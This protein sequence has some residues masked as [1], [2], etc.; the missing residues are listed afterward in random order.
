MSPRPRSIVPA[1]GIVVVLSLLSW[2]GGPGI[3]RASAPLPVLQQTPQ[4]QPPAPQEQ[5]PAAQEPQQASQEPQT[6]AGEDPTSGEADSA[7]GAR[8]ATVTLEEVEA[9]RARVEGSTELD[10]ETKKT[11]LERYGRA[12]ASLEKRAEHVA[13]AERFRKQLENAPARLTEI[14]TPLAQVPETPAFTVPAFAPL[15][16]L[17]SSLREAEAA[18]AEQAKRLAQAEQA[19]RN[20]TDRPI[21]IPQELAAAREQLAATTKALDGLEQEGGT[22]QV[23]EARR[24]RLLAEKMEFEARIDALQAELEFFQGAKYFDKQV[25]LARARQKMADDK[26][27]KLRTVVEEKRAAEAK[28][29]TRRAERLVEGLD[30]SIPLVDELAQRTVEYA[31]SAEEIN[32]NLSEAE[33]RTR[34]AEERREALQQELQ[35]IEDRLD[36]IGLVDEMGR[37]LRRKKRELRSPMEYRARLADLKKEIARLEAERI[38]LGEVR[39]ALTD[40]DAF[41]QSRMDAAGAPPEA[42][43]PVR[44]IVE[45]WRGENG[46]VT[47]LVERY[48]RYLTALYQRM[49]AE[50][51]LLEQT[52]S[53][54]SFIDERVLW[55]RSTDPGSTF[56]P[57][58]I[59]SE[60]RWLGSPT[61]WQEAVQA[62]LADLREH[63]LVNGSAVL[64]LGLLFFLQHRFRRKLLEIG[65]TADRKTSFLP[66]A[67]VF[68]LTLLLS[69]V[70]PA[71]IWVVAWRLGSSADGS[72]FTLALAD[73]LRAVAVVY[74]TFDFFGRVLRPNGLADSHFKW[75]K[76]SLVTTR[77]HLRW[78][79]AVLI[80]VV[81]V[82]ATTDGASG[83]ADWS[84]SLG[85]IACIVGF[86]ALALFCRVVLRPSGEAIGEALKRRSDGWAYRLRHL[87]YPATVLI[88]LGFVALI[89]LGYY[90]TVHELSFRLALTA[91]LLIAVI[92]VEAMIH[93]W[94]LL[95]RRRLALER[96]RKL[97]EESRSESP[98]PEAGEVIE[99]PEAEQAGIDFST[100]SEQNKKLTRLVGLTT[101]VLGLWF[102]WADVLPAF[103]ILQHV[104]V[105][106][107]GTE[108]PVTL[109]ALLFSALY[110]FATYV[111]TKNLPGLLE[112]SVLQRT[113]LGAG[114]RYAIT[115][116]SRY[117]IVIVGLILAF[118]G[119]GI[120]WSKLQWLVAA[121]SVGLGFGLQEIVANFVSGI[122]LLV[123][124]PI[125]VGDIVTV[126]T[127]SG[128]VTRIRIRATTITDW[129]RR[130]LVVPNKSFI[131][132]D[133]V[134]WTLSDT[135][136]RATYTVG[137]AYGSDVRKVMEVLI[138]SA[139]KS[140]Y[141]LEDP[142]PFAL[143]N[144]FGDSSLN[145]TLY[146]YLP[147]RDNYIAVVNDIN[148]RIN[149]A[150]AEAGIEIPFPQ[151]DIHVRDIPRRLAERIDGD[152]REPAGD[153]TPPA[154]AAASGKGAGKKKG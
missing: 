3:A 66:T 34:R 19:Q 72:P 14:E 141:V 13:T 43:E 15:E 31:R 85:S 2:L 111:A 11:L 112:I 93:R 125:R 142:A 102:V 131:T 65:K 105:W 73:G 91:W 33:E 62:F 64:I 55:I 148:T 152:G 130:E 121:L 30:R 53:F 68:V 74:L 140:E 150:L 32:R 51:Q 145:F 115:T 63:P 1:S 35:S 149:D 22:R 109:A 119:I 116:I 144:G 17:E 132:G 89:A 106:G 26:V 60:L 16:E 122:I 39:R 28:R 42:Q 6:P 48:D 126:G 138:D 82:V 100:I 107:I 44:K 81:F 147:N 75:S 61:K 67:Y 29:A 87:W 117:I 96:A 118:S 88:P 80:P 46:Y 57:E 59:L 135:V 40:V 84:D 23:Q 127:V 24:T 58:S 143:F 104:E 114:E 94:F 151:R 90:Y 153:G 52:Q 103:R 113:S 37:L 47:T 101:V 78:L 50:R 77:R 70:A 25:E 12:R 92:L 7:G 69:L 154:E 20:R 137:V 9:A 41:V 124:R 21:A 76:K 54:A 10:E 129:D 18:S 45:A 79:V 71:A 123:E 128:R 136:S 97:R 110:L 108:N 36:K 139:K 95:A 120:G 27:A 146:A 49:V 8:P 134:N 98:R 86:L 133:V 4:E 99:I 5:P 83:Q 38:N 56:D